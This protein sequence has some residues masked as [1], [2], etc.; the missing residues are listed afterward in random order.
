M[1][2]NAFRRSMNA[3]LAQAPGPER[4]VAALSG[5]MDSVVLLHLLRR[6]RDASPASPRLIAAHVNHGLRGKDADDDT[7]F[8]RLYAGS[9]DVEF[10]AK[11]IDAAGIA[12]AERLGIEEAGRN[13]RYAFFGELAPGPGGLIATGH[14]A[15]DQAETILMHLRR[16][17]HRRGR[18]GMRLVSRLPLRNGGTAVVVRPMLNLTREELRGYADEQALR[19]REDASNLDANRLRN[20]I[21]HATIPMLENIVPGFRARLLA[22]ARRLA[23]EEEEMTTA[24]RLLADELSRREDG[25]LFF[26]LDP[27]AFEVP[28]RL[29]YALRHILEEEMGGRIPYGATLSRLALLAE[30]GRPGEGVSLPGRL[31]A[32]READGIFFFYPGGTCGENGESAEIVLPDPPFDIV[33]GGLAVRAEWRQIAGL[34][35]VDDRGDPEVEWFNP[36]AI[37][38][39]LCL[40][41]PT[42]GERFRPLGAPGSRKLGDILTDLKIPRRKRGE[43]R[44]LA[45]HAGGIWLWPHRLAHRVRL[46]GDPVTA[47][48][49]RASPV[50]GP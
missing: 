8:C 23:L 21:R 2:W 13:E 9:L 45:D 28:E 6:W 47:L 39:P 15:D 25:G 31:Q 17:A 12:R 18:C 50:A 22:K 40:R 24:G 38:W 4:V 32:R 36:M 34:P 20:R 49:M 46:T 26:R 3:I 14:H 7:E 33:A 43:P 41:P 10:V 16:G 19:W 35:P 11:K 27:G 48:R 1:V 42:P 37:R 44:V 5:G 29:L 30:N